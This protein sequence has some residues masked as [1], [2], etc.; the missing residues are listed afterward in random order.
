[1]TGSHPQP[2]RRHYD[3]LRS[4][5]SAFLRKIATVAQQLW[6]LRHR[7][8][9]GDAPCY[10]DH[11]QYRAATTF[12]KTFSPEVGE[13]HDYGWVLAHAKARYERLDKT[14]HTLDD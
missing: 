4:E 12:R 9:A 6:A 1:M 3:Q 2:P 11:P 8:Q 13:E 10:T 14:F 5:T 7:R